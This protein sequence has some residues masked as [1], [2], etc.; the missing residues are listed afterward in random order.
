MDTLGDFAVARTRQEF[1]GQPKINQKVRQSKTNS[2]SQ[3]ALEPARAYS[4]PLLPASMYYTAVYMYVLCRRSLATSRQSIEAMDG[5]EEGK[6]GSREER[7]SG[8]A[9]TMQDNAYV[10]VSWPAKANQLAN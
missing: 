9:C 3:G 10:C 6:D 4:G 2:M 1:T 5:S 7:D 8:S